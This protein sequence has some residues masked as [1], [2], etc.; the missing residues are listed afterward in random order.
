MAFHIVTSHQDCPELP[1][2]V[3]EQE[4]A[5]ASVF[6][7]T[8]SA[9]PNL[10]KREFTLTTSAEAIATAIHVMLGHVRRMKRD[11]ARYR[12]ACLKLSSEDQAEL[13]RVVD[14][15]DLDADPKSG[16]TTEDEPQDEPVE[17]PN[18]ESQPQA[19][20]R[21]LRSTISVSSSVPEE[22]LSQEWPT[23]MQIAYPKEE[24]G[25]EADAVKPMP[26]K[27]GSRGKPAAS[28]GPT[29]PI[30]PAAGSVAARLPPGWQVVKKVRKSGRSAGKA[31]SY[32][33]C[34]GG[35]RCRSLA[36]VLRQKP[37]E[38]PP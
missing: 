32:F 17:V 27:K 9:D 10:K 25:Q 16:R 15:V 20:K 6:E 3:G 26:T 11:P 21:V 29:A 7:Q 4:K 35:A 13:Q 34:P 19:G 14:M 38:A 31:C 2:I 28:T 22:P 23:V 30:R 12:Q 33:A 24:M 8:P 36:E 5:L 37:A 18:D 1:R